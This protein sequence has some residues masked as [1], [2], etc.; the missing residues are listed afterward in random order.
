MSACVVMCRADLRVKAE[1]ALGKARHQRQ[2]DIRELMAS[3][4]GPNILN[5][6]RRLQEEAGVSFD[7]F[8]IP[9]KAV[10][11]DPCTG[12]FSRPQDGLRDWGLNFLVNGGAKTGVAALVLIA[13]CA[14]GGPGFRRAERV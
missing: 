13:E 11:M 8:G 14:C 2:N 5:A 4:G 6:L 10:V 1:R 9:G 12:S 3:D 7:D